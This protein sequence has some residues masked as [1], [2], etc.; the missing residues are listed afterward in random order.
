M[1]HLATFAILFFIVC[2]SSFAQH[3]EKELVKHQK[4][5]EKSL[6]K[7]KPVISLDTLFNEGKPYCVFIE[8]QKMLGSLLRATV[9]DF[10]GSEIIWILY[11]EPTQGQTNGNYEFTFVASKQKAMVAVDLVN[12]VDKVIVSY[13]LFVDGV[14]DAKAEDKFIQMHPM[15]KE[16]N[17]TIKINNDNS[18][19]LVERNRNGMVMI[20]GKDI[21]QSNVIIG[22]F[23]KESTA[24]NGTIINEINIFLPD[25]QKVARATSS[26]ATSHDWE[27]ATIKDNKLHHVT[28]SLGHDEESIVKYLIPLMYL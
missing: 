18:P 15:P 9:K 23:T 1:K 28:G 8:E 11:K 21:K 2:L 3:S 7:H 12:T 16:N 4:Q 26:G 13:N 24:A 10:N 17:I 25:G 6:S 19:K 20:M 14:F 22:Y 5:I 27:I